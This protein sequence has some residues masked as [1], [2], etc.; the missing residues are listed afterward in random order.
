LKYYIDKLCSLG[1]F[2]WEVA[3]CWLAIDA[4]NP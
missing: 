4:L 2:T 3:S 1:R